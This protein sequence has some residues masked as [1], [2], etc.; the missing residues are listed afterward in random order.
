M[1]ISKEDMSEF[2]LVNSNSRHDETS[3]TQVAQFSEDC[4]DIQLARVPRY[5]WVVRRWIGYFCS[6]RTA[7]QEIKVG[8]RLGGEMHLIGDE[9]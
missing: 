7:D 1:G 9:E 3:V 2:I 6:E 8:G 5:C 4:V